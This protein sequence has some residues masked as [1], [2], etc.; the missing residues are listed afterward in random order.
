MLMGIGKS[1]NGKGRRS[2]HK[3][4]IVVFLLVICASAANSSAFECVNEGACWW[5]FGKWTFEEVNGVVRDYYLHP[6]GDENEIAKLNVHPWIAIKALE[7]LNQKHHE[8]Y[9]AIQENAYQ[10]VYGSI[11]EDYDFYQTATIDEYAHLSPNDRL[12]YF[13]WTE[14]TWFEGQLLPKYNSTRCLN[15]FYSGLTPSRLTPRSEWTKLA[16]RTVK[17]NYT[18]AI[19][20]AITSD[21]NLMSLKHADT[22]RV[23]LFRAWGHAIHILGDMGCPPHVRDDDHASNTL[24]NSSVYEPILGKILFS[25]LDSYGGGSFDANSI[26][27]KIL[28]SEREYLD[29]LAGWTRTHFFSQGT[30][31]SSQY[32]IKDSW[33]GWEWYLAHSIYDVEGHPCKTL[34]VIASEKENNETK[35]RL[36]AAT[37]DLLTTYVL[38][39]EVEY[40]RV[41]NLR[42]DALYHFC[43]QN[44]QAFQIDEE[45]VKD[46]W[47]YSRNEIVA[48]AAG[49]IN[50]MFDNTVDSDGD[51]ILDAKDNCPIT[52]NPDQAD[53][54]G[55]GIGDACD[56]PVPL[57]GQ[58]AKRYGG[59]SKE[60]IYSIQQT[61]D[62]KFIAAGYTYSFGAGS[63]DA[64][65]LKLDSDGS[66]AWQKTYGGSSTDSIRSIQQTPDGGYIA[67]G[68]TSSF[69]A[70]DSNAWVLKLNS[71]GGIAWQKTYGQRDYNRIYS[72]QQ[73][74]DGGYIAA[75]DMSDLGW[76][77]S[78]AWVLKL[79][80]DG[81][82][83]WQKTY[84]H[85]IYVGDDPVYSIQ[86]TA[87]GGYIA[88]RKFGGNARIFKLNSDGSMAWQ[89]K[90][91]E[92]GI[93]EI[94]SIQQTADGGYVAA[95]Y[96]YSFG[97]GSSD[98]WILK[99]D[100]DGNII[101]EKSYGW[102]RSD[103]VVSIKETADGGYIAAGDT[104]SFG[105]SYSDYDSWL[106]KLRSDGSIAWQKIYGKHGVSDDEYIYSVQQTAGGG[107]VAAGSR[108]DFSMDAWILKVDSSGE[109]P[110]CSAVAESHAIVSDTSAIIEITTLVP[111]VSSAISAD[112]SVTGQ[113]TV[114]QITEVCIAP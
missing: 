88:V 12:D 106:L 45:V 15:H 70:C 55:D 99:L 22:D 71:D 68:W 9:A 109:I 79:N 11:E 42:G 48:Y 75:G 80:S 43:Q 29:Q 51:G 111:K 53:S 72:I 37:L 73:T 46:F 87:D 41:Q 101:W 28:G 3:I 61:A 1:L 98:A 10:I 13:D 20:W 102:S 65:V 76:S 91:G 92:I 33:T 85:S 64:W 100:S 107:Y 103:H 27:V 32:P 60:A 31:F 110:G 38:N 94:K 19:D 112:T 63:S 97:A 86:Q 18:D 14:M 93:D 95:G 108:G 2:M 44:G 21:I 35:V 67:A 30:M 50:C 24:K 7:V 54:D 58:W 25:E 89:K 104:N 113:D 39:T 34:Y 83:A 47:S 59:S 81:S 66:V 74:A 105:E 84:G 5:P 4:R 114:A 36:A 40:D 49:L 16:A 57:G 8:K 96:T 69:G 62:G 6:P 82:I 52:Y 26:P 23:N 77:S 90:Y 17:D 56:V 78:D